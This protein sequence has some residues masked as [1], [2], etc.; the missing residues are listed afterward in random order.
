MRAA[1]DDPA[2]RARLHQA[3]PMHIGE[4]A[5]PA[6]V[7]GPVLFLLGADARFVCGQV[8]Y[9][10]GGAEALVRPDLA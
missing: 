1:L 2:T 4:V 3:V 8:L 5:T 7:A 6:E 10:E 9:V